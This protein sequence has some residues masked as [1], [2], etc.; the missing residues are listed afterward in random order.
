MSYVFDNSP[1]S[2]LFRNYYRRTFPSLW[3]R[4]DQ[5]VT[6][7]RLV[8]TREALREIEDGAPDNLREWAKQ[9]HALFAT[10]TAAEG[11]FVA[12]I[13]SVT[14]FQQ[15]IEQQKLLRGGNIADPFVIA[16]AAVEDRAVVTMEQFKPQA[17]KIPNICRHFRV[18]CLS[19]EEFMEEEGWE[20]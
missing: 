16:K 7:G 14:H 15:N 13:Y 17:A 9:H 8:S 1:L 18:R 6:D 3:E 20:F 4:F 10:P 5:L 11:A 2:V 19:L 12:R